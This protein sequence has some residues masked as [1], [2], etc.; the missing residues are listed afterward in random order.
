[1]TQ[2]LLAIVTTKSK[3][4]K[5]NTDRD[6]NTK[7]FFDSYTDQ[8]QEI[9]AQKQEYARQKGINNP[10]HIQNLINQAIKQHRQAEQA[11]KERK[12]REKAKRQAQR[13]KEQAEIQAKD[14]QERQERERAEQRKKSFIEMFESLDE[15]YQ[16]QVLDEVAKNFQNNIFA[17]WFKEAREQGIAHKD[18]RFLGKFYE[19]F[20]F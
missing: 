1:M 2:M 11:G 7:D 17:K 20:G 15:Q 6:P 9:I 13:A 12:E 14:E 3:K 16:K 18:P 8:E 10:L 5:D 4:I 19:L